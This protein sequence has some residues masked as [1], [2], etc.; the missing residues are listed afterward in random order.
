[1]F[2]LFVIIVI[3]VFALAFIG[4]YWYIVV[5]GVLALIAVVSIPPLVRHIRKNRYF[6]SSDF[7]ARKTA[8][9]ALVAEHNEI[10]EYAKAIRDNERFSIAFSTSGE[11]AHLALSQNTSSYNYR[12]DRNVANFDATNVHNCSLQIVRNASQSP[13]KYLIKYFHIGATEHSLGSVEALGEQISRLEDAIANLKERESSIAA[14]MAPPD[15]ILKYFRSEFMEHV[16]VKLSPIR[17]PYPVYVFE[18]VSAGGNSGQKAS[19]TLDT[20]TIDTLIETLSEKIR[21]RKSAA[22]QRALMTAWLRE[23]IKKRDSY[24]CN[25]CG[26]ALSDEPHL[27]LEVDHIVPVSKGGTS[28]EANLQTLCWR[29]NRAKSNKLYG[30]QTTLQDCAK[31]AGA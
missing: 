11:H 15:F 14:T 21:F 28:T 24:T 7:H 23:H 22:G 10:A 20:P 27:L 2:Q 5:P 31:Q 29:C 17:V 26:V 12:R 16:G 19:V 13:I 30:V 1:M 3:I 4:T 8:M 6:S 18:Y 25:Y 9:S